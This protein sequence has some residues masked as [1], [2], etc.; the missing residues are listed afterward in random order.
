MFPKK[1]QIW[2]PRRTQSCPPINFCGRPNSFVTVA[3]AREKSN[4]FERRPGLQTNLALKND[5]CSRNRWFFA[6]REPIAKREAR[7]A[8]EGDAR[9]FEPKVCFESGH[10]GKF[11]RNSSSEKRSSPV[12]SLTSRRRRRRRRLPAERKSGY[13][14][15]DDDNWR[16]TN[17]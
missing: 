4:A 10:S 2:R 6:L 16:F 13:L 3:S 15:G 7:A 1:N 17:D 11:W 5:E 14:G 9:S 12:S 8:G